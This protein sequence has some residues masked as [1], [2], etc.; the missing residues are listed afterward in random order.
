MALKSDCDF[1]L[2]ALE[3]LAHLQ[4]STEENNKQ[5]LIRWMMQTETFCSVPLRKTYWEGFWPED[6][7][8]GI[9]CA[10]HWRVPGILLHSSEPGASYAEWGQ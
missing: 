8:A 10:P 4:E 9:H 2:E 5:M 7:S 3:G 1:Q 6:P